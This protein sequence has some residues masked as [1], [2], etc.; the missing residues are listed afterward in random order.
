VK[1]TSG[2]SSPK[3][4][5][6]EAQTQYSDRHTDTATGDRKPVISECVLVECVLVKCVLIECVLIECV[7]IECDK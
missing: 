5:I 4:V 7:L 3:R 1:P 6:R 2:V